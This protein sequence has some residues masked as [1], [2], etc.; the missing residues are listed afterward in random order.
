MPVN[1]TKQYPDDPNHY[2]T[3]LTDHKDSAVKGDVFKTK[4]ERKSPI[5]RQILP[6][7][8]ENL[9]H[10]ISSRVDSED[11]DDPDMMINEEG[12]H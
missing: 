8:I 10:D 5:Q 4:V 11:P 12:T 6:K 1:N 2:V 9:L 3:A 7:T